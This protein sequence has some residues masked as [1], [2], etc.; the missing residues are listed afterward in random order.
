MPSS[1]VPQ[2]NLVFSAFF[3]FEMKKSG[4]SPKYFGKE[5]ATSSYSQ[6]PGSFKKKKMNGIFYLLELTNLLKNLCPAIF[7]SFEGNFIHALCRR[8]EILHS[9]PRVD[10]GVLLRNRL[11]GRRDGYVDLRR[12]FGLE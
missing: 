8:T 12:C 7:D 11:A 1:P 3:E 9:L 4:P 10:K 5:P 6:F 2:N